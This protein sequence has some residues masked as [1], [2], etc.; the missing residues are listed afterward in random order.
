MDFLFEKRITNQIYKINISKSDFQIKLRI[1]NTVIPGLTKILLA[2]YGDVVSTFSNSMF[3]GV[4]FV[5]IF[6]S[7]PLKLHTARQYAYSNII[8]N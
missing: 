1:I 5:N 6:V 2:A 4:R 3:L 8:Q 7:V